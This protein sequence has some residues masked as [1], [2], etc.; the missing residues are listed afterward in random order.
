VAS[1]YVLY[2]QMSVTGY[3]DNRQV[4]PSRN[5]A[6]VEVLKPLRH[7][8]HVRALAD[9][10][11]FL[12]NEDG[13]SDEPPP[14]PF[15]HPN[16]VATFGSANSIGSVEH[17]PLSRPS[18]IPESL[19]DTRDRIAAADTYESSASGISLRQPLVMD[20]IRSTCV[21]AQRASA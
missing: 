3:F 10:V 20:M 8:A 17:A 18:W 9:C 2:L 1:L 6:I 21:L 12:V 5:A 14:S 13:Y 19:Q 11:T 4:F 15:A 16:Q 7:P